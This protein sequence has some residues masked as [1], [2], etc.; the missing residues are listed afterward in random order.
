M[1]LDRHVRGLMGP[2]QAGGIRSP[3]R[4]APEAA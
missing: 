4:P 3:A 2:A 1:P